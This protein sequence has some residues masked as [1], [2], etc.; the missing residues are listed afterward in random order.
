MARKLTAVSSLAALRVN[1]K[2]HI[3]IWHHILPYKEMPPTVEELMTRLIGICPPDQGWILHS[4]QTNP[5]GPGEV[6]Y[7]GSICARKLDR[8][9]LKLA[10]D[11]V[12]FTRTLN[13]DQAIE[14][15]WDIL[16]KRF[17]ADAGWGQAS[18]IIKGV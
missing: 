6:A 2:G 3:E 18:I 12:V 15:A 5:A 7:I 8:N 1:E 11:T 17:P 4:V 16:G 13:R 10:H 14:S 9:Q